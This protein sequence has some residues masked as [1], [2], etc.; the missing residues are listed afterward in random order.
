MTEENSSRMRAVEAKIPGARL[1]ALR[2]W[3]VVGAIA[4]GAALLD[5]LGVLA[6]V[7]EFLAVGSLIGP[8]TSRF[9]SDIWL[10]RLFIVLALYVGTDYVLRGFFNYRIFG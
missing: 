1:L 3:T 10:K 6:P 9:F 8:Y 7:I 4:I 2:V 5:V